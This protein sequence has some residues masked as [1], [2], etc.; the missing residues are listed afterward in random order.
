MQT[1]KHGFGLNVNADVCMTWLRVALGVI[2]IIGGIKL[3]FLGDTSALAASYTNPEKGWLSPVFAD[4]I[5]QILGI[6]VGPFLRTQGLVEI[7]LGLLMALGI[8]TRVV[9]VIMGLMFW[10]FAAAN[11]VA[12]E[13]RLSRDLALMGCCFAVAFAGAGAWSLDGRLWQRSSTFTSYQDGILVLIRLSLAFTLLTSAVFASGP[14]ANHLNTTLPLVMVLVM[15]ALLAV[16]LRPHWIMGLLALWM[17]YV[18][19]ASMGAKGVY[20]GLDSAKRELGFLVAAVVYALLGPDRWAWLEP[21]T[22]AATSAE[23]AESVS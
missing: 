22:S 11:P 7:A 15:G 20:F 1:S 5:T 4:K 14:F 3:A 2:F 17:L 6:G 16:G 10:V 8:G 9:A 13:I 19:A 21:Q 18:V 12:G 23:Y